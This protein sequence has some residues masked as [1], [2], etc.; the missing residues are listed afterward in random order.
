VLKLAKGRLLAFRFAN[1]CAIRLVASPR[2]A[3]PGQL[4]LRAFA[5]AAL[6]YAALAP[7]SAAPQVHIEYGAPKTYHCEIKQSFD[8]PNMHT[9]TWVLYAPLAPATESQAYV[10]GTFT[11]NGASATPTIVSECSALRRPMYG[12]ILQVQPGDVLH[13]TNLDCEVDYSVTEWPRRLAA[14]P[15]RTHIAPLDHATRA[16]CLAAGPTIDY[17]DRRFQAWL[18]RNALRRGKHETDLEFARHAFDTIRPMYNYQWIHGESASCSDVCARNHADCGRISCLFVS[19]LRANGI[20]ARPLVGHNLTNAPSADDPTQVHVISEFYAT[21]IGWIPVDMSAAI[22]NHAAPASDSFGTENGVFLTMHTDFDMLV[23]SV[24][25][26]KRNQWA[27]QMPI[28]FVRGP[29]S[30]AGFSSQSTWQVTTSDRTATA[31]L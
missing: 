26:G 16:A 17:T 10:S 30:I 2:S 24:Y 6:T 21:G 31:A 20:P 14:G 8:F 28:A 4:A 1:T 18:T 27:F 9:Q 25:F 19:T 15:S 7:A 3:G 5:A 13:Q 12:M 11:V 22:S 29:G 23:D